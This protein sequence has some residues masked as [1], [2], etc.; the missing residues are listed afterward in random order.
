MFALGCIVGLAGFSR[1]LSFLMDR[2]S[3]VTLAALTGLMLGSL[4]KIW[5]FKEVIESKIINNKL[6]VIREMNIFPENLNST[7]Y[8]SFGLCVLGF[9]LIIIL[10]K[11]ATRK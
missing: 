5:P 2:Y 9:V 8:I 11:Y 1:V 6:V 3:N 4:R 7:F 10:E